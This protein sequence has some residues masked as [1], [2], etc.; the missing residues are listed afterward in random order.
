MPTLIFTLG[1]CSGGLRPPAGI[2]ANRGKIGGQRPPLQQRKTGNERVES[3]S[4]SIQK[5]G[6]SRRRPQLR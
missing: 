4:A 6:R 1:F 3:F 5:R 2:V